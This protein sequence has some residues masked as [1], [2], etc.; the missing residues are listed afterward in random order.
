MGSLPSMRSISS[1]AVCDCLRDRGIPSPTRDCDELG[2]GKGEP[3]G[4]RLGP[5]RGDSSP[6]LF[7]WPIMGNAG[8]NVVNAVHDDDGKSQETWPNPKAVLI[9]ISLLCGAHT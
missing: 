5:G 2:V 1:F 7:I 4:V 6:A 8:G 3:D 9:P